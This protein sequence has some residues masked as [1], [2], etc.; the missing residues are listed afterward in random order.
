MFYR[1]TPLFLYGELPS[2]LEI[3]YFTLIDGQTQIAVQYDLE[4]YGKKI[5]KV[6]ATAWT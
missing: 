2:L 3:K 5:R 1:N 6:K 4:A